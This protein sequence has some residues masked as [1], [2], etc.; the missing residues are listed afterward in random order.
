MILVTGFGSFG[1]VTDNPTAALVRALSGRRV[2]GRTVVGTVLPVSY[3]EGLDLARRWVTRLRPEL[4][5]GFGVAVS[6]DRVDVES[7]AY[8]Q[9][10]RDRADVVGEAPGV[11]EPLGP[12]AVRATLD[13]HGLADALDARVSE[14]AGRYVCNA[15]LYRMV[16]AFPEV[17]LTFVHVP[18]EGVEVERV[19]SGLDR[20]LG[21]APLV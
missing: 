8:N 1:E 20:F 6:R 21:R 4:V 14:D 19:L 3:G 13:V 5:V 17:P 12:D 15:W 7:V 2:R 10:H 11:L 9:T 18:P 16:R